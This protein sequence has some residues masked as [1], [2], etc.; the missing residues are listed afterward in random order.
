MSNEEN[1]IPS[2]NSLPLLNEEEAGLGL[3]PS[4]P[5]KIRDYQLEEVLCKNGSLITLEDGSKFSYLPFW[6]KLH[7]DGIV[8]EF[9]FEFIPIELSDW[10]NKKRNSILK[11]TNLDLNP[12]TPEDCIQE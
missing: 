2:I 11:E 9:S 3:K 4:P 7:G 10:I 8:E 1:V 6:Y 5:M 12:L